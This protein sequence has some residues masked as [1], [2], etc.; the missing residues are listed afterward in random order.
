MASTRLFLSKALVRAV[1][2][3]TKEMT[4]ALIA[5]ALSDGW[6]PSVAET[7]KVKRQPAKLTANNSVHKFSAEVK[8][9]TEA[10][11]AEYGRDEGTPKA[12][13]RKF[14]SNSKSWEKRTAKAFEKATFGRGRK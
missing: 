5:N 6:D 12:T 11:D 14:M 13:V 9:G 7:L 4:N 1:E 3:V 10:F 8:D 2:S